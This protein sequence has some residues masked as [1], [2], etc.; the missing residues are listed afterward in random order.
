M[1]GPKILI[2]CFNKVLL[3]WRLGDLSKKMEIRQ[4]PLQKLRSTRTRDEMPSDQLFKVIK[5]AN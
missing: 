5:L 2:S 4:K 1:I 3:A